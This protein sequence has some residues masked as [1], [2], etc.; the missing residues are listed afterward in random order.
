MAFDTKKLIMIMRMT[1]SGSDGEAL[2]AVRLAN[3]M[4]KADGKTWQDV[5]GLTSKPTITV[6]PDYRTPPSKRGKGNTSRYGRRAD[7][8]RPDDGNK[9][10]GSDIDSMLSALGSR[11][12]EVSTLM[13]IAGL[14]DFWERNGFLTTPQYEALCNVHSFDD[15]DRGGRGGGGGR[16]RF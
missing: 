8:R 4:L 6:S 3:R 5:I 13:F 9:H 12:H 2:N 10:T 7:Q 14:R 15:L 16:W 1:E 11:K